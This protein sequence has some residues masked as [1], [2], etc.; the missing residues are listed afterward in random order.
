LLFEQLT[1]INDPRKKNLK[2]RAKPQ[3]KRRMEKKMKEQTQMVFNEQ[4]EQTI[5]EEH[6]RLS[7]RLRT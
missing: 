3:L 2:N 6:A 7:R 1:V 5:C 4:G